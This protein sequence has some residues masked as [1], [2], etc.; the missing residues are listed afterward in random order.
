MPVGNSS[1]QFRFANISKGKVII[2]EGD[3]YVPYGFIEG[4]LTDI[5]I[6]DDEHKGKKFKKV[7]FILNDGVDQ[8]NF[9]MK[10]NSGYARA[11]CC[12]I[13]NANLEQP[14]RFS[15]T[16]E[17]ING[18]TKTGMFINQGAAAI[19]WKWTK[20]NPGDLPPLKTVSISGQDHWDN[21]EQTAFFTNLLLNE[22]KP[23]LVAPFLAGPAHQIDE[24]AGKPDIPSGAEIEDDLPF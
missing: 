13:P 9:A 11:I 24:T 14:I 1:R 10:L 6:V 19:K 17:E 12:T 23:K 18:K 15:P 7:C 5:Q 8:W 2:K 16:F 4:V 3:V 22:I 20:D 21:T